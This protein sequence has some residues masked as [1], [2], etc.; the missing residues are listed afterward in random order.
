MESNQGQALYETKYI[1]PLMAGFTPTQ[2]PRKPQ[3]VRHFSNSKFF[4]ATVAE[5]GIFGKGFRISTNQKRESTV[6]SLLI[7]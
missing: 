3:D 1:A 2:S 6:F 7:G 4:I 5:H